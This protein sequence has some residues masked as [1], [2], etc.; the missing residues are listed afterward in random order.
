MLSRPC[1][2]S[3]L[4]NLQVKDVVLLL[5]LQVLALLVHGLC[6]PG[7]T[8]WWG[9]LG[10]HGGSL[11]CVMLCVYFC[12]HFLQQACMSQHAGSVLKL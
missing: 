2:V 4:H 5:L 11:V 6:Q 7:T 3:S 9:G 1:S 10:G 12:Q 8:G